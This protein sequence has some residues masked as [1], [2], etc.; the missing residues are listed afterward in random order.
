MLSLHKNNYFLSFHSSIFHSKILKHP[1][2]KMSTDEQ[3]GAGRKLEV[4]SQHTF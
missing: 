1:A 2:S 4:L 3:G